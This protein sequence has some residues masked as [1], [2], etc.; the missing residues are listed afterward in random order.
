MEMLRQNVKTKFSDESNPEENESKEEETEKS[1]ESESENENVS[2]KRKYHSSSDENSDEE[3]G[4]PVKKNKKT[5]R[6][7][8]KTPEVKGGME[9]SKILSSEEN[10]TRKTILLSATLTQAVEKLA[11]LTMN[12]PIF[13]DAAKENLEMLGDHTS[14]INEDLIVPQSVTQSYIV[15]PPKLRMVTLSAYIVGKCQVNY[16]L[17]FIQIC[18]YNFF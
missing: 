14:D 5:T 1:N 9:N 10:H 15:T 8:K 2:I 4:F 13:V 6:I 18:I 7:E 3:E 11:G 12:N 16:I 17:H